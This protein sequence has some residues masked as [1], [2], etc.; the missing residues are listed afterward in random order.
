MAEDW[1]LLGTQMETCR[2]LFYECQHHRAVQVETP[3]PKI[4]LLFKQI[5]G[6]ATC[7]LQSLQRQLV[8][9]IAIY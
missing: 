1:F 4:F 9:K 7:T 5:S 3:F 6:P 2:I 8:N